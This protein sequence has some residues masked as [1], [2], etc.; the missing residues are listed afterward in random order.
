[1]TKCYMSMVESVY[2]RVS[3]VIASI[4]HEE[5]TDVLYIK[6][7]EPG[8]GFTVMLDPATGLPLTYKVW[9]AKYCKK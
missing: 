8:S 6:P 9:E 5:T 1:M 2:N 4:Y 7:C 3:G